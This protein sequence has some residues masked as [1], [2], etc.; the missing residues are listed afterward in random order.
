MTDNSQKISLFEDPIIEDLLGWDILGLVSLTLCI[1]L[2]FV[3]ATHGQS[4]KSGEE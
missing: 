1:Y 4:S 2:A 3:W